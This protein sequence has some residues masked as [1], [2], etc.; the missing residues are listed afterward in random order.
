MTISRKGLTRLGKSE[1]RGES[2]ETW[3]KLQ[4]AGW[5]TKCGKCDKAMEM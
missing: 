4:S 2:D 5:V 3:E 1:K